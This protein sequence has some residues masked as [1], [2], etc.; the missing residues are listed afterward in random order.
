[1]SRVAI[2]RLLSAAVA[3]LSCAGLAT[4]VSTV[5]LGHDYVKG[6]VPMFRLD[7]EQNIPTFFSV[8]LMIMICALL[9]TAGHAERARHRPHAWAWT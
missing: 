8:L 6:L 4:V 1:M 9:I 3:F 5:H 7:A 2:V